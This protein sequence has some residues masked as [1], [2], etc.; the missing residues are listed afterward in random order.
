MSTLS[1]LKEAVDEMGGDFIITGN[2]DPVN[3]VLNGSKEII[4]NEIKRVINIGRT[5]RH[6]FILAAGCDL[7]ASTPLTHVDWFMEAARLYS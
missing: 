1:N 5:S 4:F 3:I 7:P 6:G 2:V